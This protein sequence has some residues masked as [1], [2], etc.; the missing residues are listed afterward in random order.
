MFE[1][2]ILFNY[3]EVFITE[4]SA[5]QNLRVHVT[6]VPVLFFQLQVLPFTKDV[7]DHSPLFL[8]SF[9]YFSFPSLQH[10]ILRPF[11]NCGI[12]IILF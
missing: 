10:A 9:T 1:N 11:I 6:Q 2:L 5:C 8:I 3:K 7:R 4:I 12:C